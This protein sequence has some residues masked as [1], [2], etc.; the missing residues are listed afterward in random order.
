MP[1]VRHAARSAAD[2]SGEKM[3]CEAK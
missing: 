3:T 1:N 2:A